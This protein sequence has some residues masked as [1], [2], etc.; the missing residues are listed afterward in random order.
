LSVES[1]QI[2]DKLWPSMVD[3]AF[4]VKLRDIVKRDIAPAADDID[5]KD[6]YP[7]IG[8]VLAHGSDDDA[9]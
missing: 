4:V 1:E 2:T 8:T 5:E 9:V 7:A 3:A 6:Y